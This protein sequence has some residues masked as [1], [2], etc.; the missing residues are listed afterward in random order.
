MVTG[1]GAH[2]IGYV[3]VSSS[4]RG[5]LKLGLEAQRKAIEQFAAADGFVIERI[6]VEVVTSRDSESIKRRPQLAAALSEA[7]RLRCAICV[8]NLDRLSCSVAFISAL[9]AQRI[10]F[11][12]AEIGPDAAPF[13]LCTFARLPQKERA[14]ISS[15][16]KAALAGAKARGVRLGNPNIHLAGQIGAESIRATA[17]QNAAKVLP[18]I[19]E[20]QRS[21][22][23]SFQAIA[24]E[25]NAR[26]ISTPRGGRWHGA[27][28]RNTL[29]RAK[30]LE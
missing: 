27:G 21:G 23:K 9:M 20:I 22:V 29:A 11:I 4:K 16:T 15:R 26:G 5:R 17:D 2:L 24:K 25:L 1:Y 8:A 12:V 18:I 3:R 6:F 10:P 28:V 13:I 19:R 30:W 14:T 7:R